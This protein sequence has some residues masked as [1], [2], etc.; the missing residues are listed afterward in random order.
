MILS[1]ESVTSQVTWPL[2]H[3]LYFLWYRHLSLSSGLT[4]NVLSLNSGRST[5]RQQPSEGLQYDHGQNHHEVYHLNLLFI[6]PNTM[7]YFVN[8]SSPSWSHLS[9]SS[10]TWYRFGSSLRLPD[11]PR[12]IL[13][14][15]HNRTRSRSRSRSPR[16]CCKLGLRMFVVGLDRRIACPM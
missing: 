13:S 1:P 16:L 11:W 4:S 6:K 8:W 15:S 10:F 12:Q 9:P 5:L 14:S 2:F 3:L 7:T